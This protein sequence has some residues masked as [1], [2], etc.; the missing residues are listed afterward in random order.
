MDA[1]R[2]I[3]AAARE[4]SIVHR[5]LKRMPLQ[6][7][8]VNTN[9]KVRLPLGQRGSSTKKEKFVRLVRP[10]ASCVERKFPDQNLKI[11]AVPAIFRAAIK[12]E[13][14]SFEKNPRSAGAP[15]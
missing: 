14:D 7:L 2:G 9:Q 8:T 13:L 15:C 10:P 12:L 1:E 11:I 4:S 5:M 3:N 6:R